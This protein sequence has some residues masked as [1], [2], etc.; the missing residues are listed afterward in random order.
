V[1]H[2]NTSSLSRAVKQ[3]RLL[4]TLLQGNVNPS[5]RHRKYWI[6]RLTMNRLSLIVYRTSPNYLDTLSVEVDNF[7][8]WNSILNTRWHYFLCHVIISKK[9]PI[10]LEVLSPGITEWEKF[11]N[12]LRDIM[13]YSYYSALAK[14]PH[15][16]GT[17][18]L[19]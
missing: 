2:A 6:E 5:Y 9:H 3:H 4:S 1:F 15:K 8:V 17:R 12:F 14:Y 19:L 7:W 16:L 18:K 11:S 13:T 10:S